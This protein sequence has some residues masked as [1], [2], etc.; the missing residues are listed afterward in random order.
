M[1]PIHY[2]RARRGPYAF[3]LCED[4]YAKQE[5]KRQAMYRVCGSHTCG[6]SSRDCDVCQA[7]D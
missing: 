3:I 1:P 2:Y 7:E 5:P 4:C 6:T